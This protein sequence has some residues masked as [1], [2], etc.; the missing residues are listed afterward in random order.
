MVPHERVPD[1]AQAVSVREPYV[2]AMIPCPF[3]P[4]HKRPQVVAMRGLNLEM[5]AVNLIKEHLVEPDSWFGLCPSSNMPWPLPDGAE[6]RLYEQA[7]NL[8]RMAAERAPVQGPQPPAPVSP[9]R[10]GPPNGPS[11]TKWFRNSEESRHKP[12]PLQGRPHLRLVPDSSEKP[13]GTAHVATVAEVQ[14]ALAVADDSIQNAIAAAQLAA[15]RFEEAQQQINW[16][17]STSVD[18]LS[19]PAIAN[20]I[21]ACGRAIAE[22]ARAIEINQTYRSTM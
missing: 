8:R 3:N 2:P 9:G 21:G 1:L 18:P 22:G 12:G 11:S 15:E 16:I 20:A 19:A 4:C 7:V 13:K 10:G 17:K 6:E 5:P 14:A